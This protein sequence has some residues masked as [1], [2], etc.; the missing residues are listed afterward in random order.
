MVVSFA[1]RTPFPVVAFQ[2][3][4]ANQLTDKNISVAPAASQKSNQLPPVWLQNKVFLTNSLNLNHPDKVGW[5]DVNNYRKQEIEKYFDEVEGGSQAILNHLNSV[6]SRPPAIKQWDFQPGVSQFV[7]VGEGS[8][9]N[10]AKMAGK[11]YE[12]QGFH[13]SYYNPIEAK[14]L[15]EQEIK[16]K[17]KPDAFKN[18]YYILISQ[19]GTTSVLVNYAT[20]LTNANLVNKDHIAVVTNTTDSAK[21]EKPTLKGMF[22]NTTVQIN[23]GTESSIASTKAVLGTVA[24]IDSLLPKHLQRY[25]TRSTQNNLANLFNVQYLN[26][27]GTINT[28]KTWSAKLNS[29]IATSTAL[30]DAAVK[31]NELII[32]GPPTYQPLLNEITLKLRETAL[33]GREF[34]NSET[35]KHGLR[36]VLE[37]QQ[38]LL[39]VLPLTKEEQ[40]IVLNDLYDSL[41]RYELLYETPYNPEKIFIVAPENHQLIT[42]EIK[43]QRKRER[44]PAFQLTS[45]PILRVP[46]T[47]NSLE[48]QLSTLYLMQLFCGVLTQQRLNLKT[49][50][51]PYLDKSVMAKA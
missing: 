22:P 1:A 24:A 20:D 31:N 13:V 50:N 25:L 46:D 12:E 34:S 2:G 6:D 40:K 4:L 19:S 29:G 18:T 35:F 30:N 42:D 32:L 36:P 11:A 39:V 8:S 23:A 10:A 28:L 45:N 49:F 7:F 48:H 17:L 16:N 38:P 33:A 9:L 21:E 27:I 5:F 47:K 41:R 26:T 14:A 3:A 15:L 43:Q 37:F 51:S 44:L